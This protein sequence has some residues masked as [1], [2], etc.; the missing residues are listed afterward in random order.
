MNGGGSDGEG[1]SGGERE[2]WI[3]RGREEW[4][5]RQ[6]GSDGG[7][8]AMQGVG[9]DDGGRGRGNDGRRGREGEHWS[10]LTWAHCCT[11]LS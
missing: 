9:A 3:V 7:R 5:V 6:V 8:G 2:W 1:G 10:S 11:H 4:G